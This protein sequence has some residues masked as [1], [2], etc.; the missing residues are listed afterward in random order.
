MQKKACFIFAESW[1]NSTIS[2]IFF[3]FFSPELK[4]SALA[5]SPN[6]RLRHWSVGW[7]WLPSKTKNRLKPWWFKA[8]YIDSL[9]L[10]GY[11]RFGWVDIDRFQHTFP[12]S[13][14]T[15]E[16]KVHEVSRYSRILRM[17]KLF[18]FSY[19]F[20]FLSRS[21]RFPHRASLLSSLTMLKRQ[22]LVSIYS[23]SITTFLHCL[24][25]TLRSMTFGYYTPHILY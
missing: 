20:L 12:I 15:S 4:R 17:I 19:Y 18:H 16:P 21:L 9:E 11:P 13:Q 10:N 23:D 14:K 1:E 24:C 5:S 8:I 7:C 22:C 25:F 6:S 3:A 2:H